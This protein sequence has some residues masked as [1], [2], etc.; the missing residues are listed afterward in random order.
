MIQDRSF[1][2]DGQLFYFKSWMPE[3]FGNVALVNGRVWP[4]LTVEP[5]KYR[6]RFLNASNARFYDLKLF[7]SDAS[8]QPLRVSGQPAPGPAFYQIGSD[9]GFLPAPVKLND[10]SDPRS[11]RLL[12]GVAERA[13]VVIDFSAYAGR[14]FVMVNDAKAPFKGVD[15]PEP[16]EA[17]LAEIMMFS[18]SAAP[19]SDPSSLPA[20]LRAV[21]RISEGDAARTRDLT[22]EEYEDKKGEPTI[23]LLSGRHFDDPVTEKPVMGTTE[24][25][26]IINLTED[27]HPIHLHFVQFQILDH[28]PIDV[29]KPH[30]EQRPVLLLPLAHDEDP[31]R[32]LHQLAAQGRGRERGETRREHL[33]AGVVAIEVFR[34]PATV[35]VGGTDEENAFAAQGRLLLRGF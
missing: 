1:T 5:R 4:R 9:G 28:R 17:P 26:R 27:V 18:V 23:M 35:D 29:G 14:H 6:F 22:L 7:E 30:L 13:D 20:Q 10:P 19:V 21:P 3:F 31:V 15:S 25:W 33:V 32:P 16:D 12:M 8:G 24:I 11:P 2:R 34:G